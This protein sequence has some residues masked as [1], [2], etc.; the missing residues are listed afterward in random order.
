LMTAG[1]IAPSDGGVNTTMVSGTGSAARAGD[2]APAATNA[3]ASVI[4]S[5]PIVPP[6]KLGQRV[7]RAFTIRRLVYNS[8]PM[9]LDKF[10]AFKAQTMAVPNCLKHV[11]R[12]APGSG[13]I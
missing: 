5:L 3:A 4:A 6:R 13:Y 8:S 10:Q 2:A 9:V 7:L 12:A 1:K 11:R